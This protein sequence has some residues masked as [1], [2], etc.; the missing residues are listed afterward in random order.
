MPPSHAPTAL[1]ASL[2]ALL[3]GLSLI[4]TLPPARGEKADRAKPMEI[5]A[6]RSGTAD[7]QAQVTRFTGN[8]VITQGTLLIKADRVEVRTTPDGYHM[9]SAWGSAGAPV[10]YRQKRD[11]VDEFVEGVAERVEFDGKAE[12]LRFIGSGVVRRLAG[13]QTLD[14]IT[15][16]LIVWNHAAEQFSVQGGTPSASS[17]AGRVR[18]VLSPRPGSAAASEAPRPARAASEPR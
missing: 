1:R 13:S 4:A 5:Q 18:A 9:G 7:L 8:V 6:D 14:E 11:G 17:P 2:P 16:S 15:G 3:L 10:Y 12:V